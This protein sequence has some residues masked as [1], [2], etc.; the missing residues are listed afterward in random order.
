M[1]NEHK[2]VLS[3]FLETEQGRYLVAVSAERSAQT[4]RAIQQ[5]AALLPPIDLY[6]PHVEHRRSWVPSQPIA[7][8]AL[9]DETSPLFGRLADGS[10]MSIDRRSTAPT[11]I[12]ILLLGP[13]EAKVERR[14]TKSD[15]CFAQQ[16]PGIAASDCG[17]GGGGGGGGG[18]NVYLHGDY[19]G[20]Y[21]I[22]DNGFCS[23][24]NEFELRAQDSNGTWHSPVLRCTEVPST[25]TINIAT[26]PYCNTD[27]VHNSSPIEVSYIDVAVIETDG[28]PNPDDQFL[29][30][31]TYNCAPV[32]P[33]VTHNS[34]YEREFLLFGYP[35]GQYCCPV[36]AQYV[37]VGFWW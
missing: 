35:N 16:F 23:E 31:I 20:T 13:A 27:R 18:D 21:D 29:D 3:E 5:L 28:W 36:C 2:V 15:T 17:G 9:V 4:V 7:V 14:A 32:T 11:E 6:V 10:L 22:C 24:T 8:T 33:R 37:G 34:S 19:I 12:A 30:Y 1:F 26:H 25:G